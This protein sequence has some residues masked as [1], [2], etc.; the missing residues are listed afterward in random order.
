MIT[1]LYEDLSTVGGYITD[2]DINGQGSHAVLEPGEP[3][4]IKGEFIAQNPKEHPVRTMQII[5]FRNDEF[6]KCIY[7]DI[8]PA[9]PD[10]IKGTFS[11]RCK[12]PETEGTYLI[13]SGWAYNWEWPEDAYKYLL[14]NPMRIETIGRFT[15]GFVVE[16]KVLSLIPYLI[17]GLPAVTFLWLG[18]KE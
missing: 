16:E 1:L 12:A 3:L 14:A 6:L 11:F 7:N 10:Y 5:L 8:P 4:T 15:V 18:R 13:R 9:E 2:I 17:L